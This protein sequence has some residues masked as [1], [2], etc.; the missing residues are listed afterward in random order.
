MNGFGFIEYDDAMDARDV[1]PGRYSIGI[2][3][4]E[5]I[6]DFSQSSL[7]YVPSPL[8]PHPSASSVRRELF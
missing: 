7:P 1:V 2:I 6:A 4:N 5:C 3:A 8:T